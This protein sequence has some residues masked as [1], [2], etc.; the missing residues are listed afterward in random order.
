MKAK[1]RFWVL[2]LAAM[3]F[4]VSLALAPG[5]TSAGDPKDNRDRS[6]STKPESK[7]RDGAAEGESI[8]ERD[9]VPTRIGAPPSSSRRPGAIKRI[10]NLFKGLFVPSKGK[11]VKASEDQ[12][13]D[14][15][16]PDLP[17]KR[18]MR[19]GIDK[20]EYLR[21]RDEYIA[22]LRG[23]D[24]AHPLNPELRVEALNQK[25]SQQA[26]MARAAQSSKG[27]IQPLLS[28]TTWTEIG[29]RPV[30]NGQTQQFPATAAVTGRSTMIVVDPTNSNKVYL[31]TAQGGVWRSLDGG[32]TWT[33]IFDTA[34]SLSVGAKEESGD[35]SM[36]AQRGQPSLTPRNHFQLERWHWRL[37]TLLS[38]M[39]AP[40]SQIIPV[41]VS[42]V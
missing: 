12:D 40:A 1:M 36:E 8:R 27:N 20:E 25:E 11:F 38:S 35:L 19:K 34:Q 24:P 14:G 31:G 28:G 22:S 21:L 16:D 41:I 33:A 42:L 18:F 23:L 29:P 32:T 2:T 30:P 37:P 17:A 26:E 3:L 15:D 7:S 5:G 10:A 6:A 4:G 39:S 9:N 13:I